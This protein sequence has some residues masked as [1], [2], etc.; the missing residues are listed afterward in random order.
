MAGNLGFDTEFKVKRTRRVKKFHEEPSNT[1]HYL[2][3]TEKNFEVNIFNMALDHII[4]QIQSRFN[5]VKKVSSQFSFI[6]LQSEDPYSQDDN[7]LCQLAKFYSNDVKEDDLVEEICHFDRLKASSLFNRGNS[8]NL[9]NQIYSKG[10]QPIFPSICILLRI[11]HTMP[12]SV[13]EGERSFSKLKIIKNHFKATMGQERLSNLM[14]LS[15]ENDLAKS[16]SYDE[17]IYNFASKK[18]R[19]FYLN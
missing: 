1:V 16:L 8:L 2:D 12:I 7:E 14:M 15:I 17:V 4:L 5:V 19:K 18:A 13:A 9:L 11:F 6:W 3:D 10:L